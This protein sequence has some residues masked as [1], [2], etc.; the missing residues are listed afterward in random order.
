MLDYT[1]PWAKKQ[2]RKYAIDLIN[3]LLLK[4]LL[5]LLFV[6]YSISHSIPLKGFLQASP[7]K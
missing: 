4:M 3:S 5:K 2:K 7:I 1:T 6:G